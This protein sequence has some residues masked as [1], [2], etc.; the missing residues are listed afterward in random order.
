M[1]IVNVPF[2]YFNIKF[3]FFLGKK[4]KF[5]GIVIC[6]LPVKYVSVYNRSQI[7]FALQNRPSKT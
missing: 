2:F 4:D 7:V 1:H 5:L 3:D 6:I